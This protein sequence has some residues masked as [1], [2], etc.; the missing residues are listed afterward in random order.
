MIGRRDVLFGCCCG[1]M[2]L[3][4]GPARGQQRLGPYTKDEL[5]AVRDT[6]EPYA[7]SLFFDDLLGRLP[8]AM[9]RPLGEVQLDIPAEMPAGPGSD[10]A[11]VLSVAS[12]PAQRQ[13]YLPLRTLRWLREYCGL[14]VELERRK[15]ADRQA[16]VMVYSGMLSRRVQ[17]GARPPGPLAAFGLD[18]GIYRDAYVDNLSSDLFG[19]TLFFLL[20]HEL[21]HIARGHA[22]GASGI[23]SQLQEREADAYALDAMA[24]VGVMPLGLAAFFSAAAMMEGGQTTH[25]LS[26]SRVEAIARGLEA[27]PRAFVDPSQPNPEAAAA[28]LL[29][30]AREIRAAVPIIDDPELRA[31]LLRGGG[32]GGDFA[33][34]RSAHE[35]LC[36]Q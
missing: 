31:S 35:R 33:G 8:P 30:N 36:T 2:L 24:S 15:C 19:R 25:P 3:G 7:R 20:A 18:A 23:N 13:V 22:V 16:I 1:L 5:E 26:G 29:A 9:R 11:F 10:P 12:V 4:A 28:R 34:L 14:V 21:G 32:S 17:G 27:R 6:Y